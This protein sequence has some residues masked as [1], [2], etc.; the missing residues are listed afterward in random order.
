MKQQCWNNQDQIGRT[1]EE[2]VV[3]KQNAVMITNDDVSIKL[4]PAPSWKKAGFDKLHIFCFKF[5]T[6]VNGVLASLNGRFS[7]MAG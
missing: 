5:F 4:K 1:K 6:A 3:E 7:R 2:I